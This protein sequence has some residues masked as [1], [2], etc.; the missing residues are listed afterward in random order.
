MNQNCLK[1]LDFYIYQYSK[2]VFI[3]IS[4][5][6]KITELSF[7]LHLMQTKKY[8]ILHFQTPKKEGI[9]KLILFY[10]KIAEIKHI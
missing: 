5:F 3:I 6:E 2:V 4:I 7:V 9:Y 8:N 1:C 10:L